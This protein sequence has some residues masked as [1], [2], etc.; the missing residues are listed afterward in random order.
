MIRNTRIKTRLTILIIKCIAWL[1]TTKKDPIGTL[2]ILPVNNFGKRMLVGVHFLC[3]VFFLSC[4]PFP[5]D[6]Q[7]NLAR[8][9]K[10]Y[11]QFKEAD[12][13]FSNFSLDID[14]E[15]PYHVSD[16]FIKTAKEI[17]DLAYTLNQQGIPDEILENFCPDLLYIRYLA[18]NFLRSHL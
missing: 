16:T 14:N 8:L 10:L 17:M 3:R 5:T 15:V 11:I 1:R 4:S 13:Q 6:T 12:G 18:K 9:H 2:W 7:S